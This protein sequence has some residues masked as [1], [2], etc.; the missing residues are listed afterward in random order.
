[1]RALGQGGSELGKL[2]KDDA[3]MPFG[4]RDVLPRLLVLVRRLV[5]SESVVKLR[6]LALRTSASPPRNPMRLILFWYMISS[7]FVEF[8]VS[9][10]GHTPAKPSEGPGSQGRSSA[11][12]E[13]PEKS[14]RRTSRTRFGAETVT[15]RATQ[16]KQKSELP[17]GAGNAPKP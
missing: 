9:C 17:Q 2:A 4:L 10:S 11:F 13:A 14:F 7:P 1:M 15:Q 5:A 3:A 8:P 12:A 16:S 6:L